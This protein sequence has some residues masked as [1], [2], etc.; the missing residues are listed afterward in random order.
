MNVKDLAQDLERRINRV[1]N[2]QRRY[3]VLWIVGEPRCGK[4]SL[5][6]SLC[7]ELGWRYVNFTLDQGFLDTLIGKE[8]TYRPEDFSNDLSMWCAQTSEEILILDE[9]EPL[10]SLW[11]WEQQEIFFRQIGRA[12]GLRVGVVIVTR[13]RSAQQLQ[14]VLLEMHSDHIYEMQRGVDSWHR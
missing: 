12:T 6:R 2:A 8:Q 3:R 4:T 5:C 10:L 11:N 1:C 13:S 7:V 9:I 14:Q